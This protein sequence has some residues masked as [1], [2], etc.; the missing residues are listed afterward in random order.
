MKLMNGEEEKELFIKDL[1][2][3]IPLVMFPLVPKR[4]F[5]IQL[6]KNIFMIMLKDLDLVEDSDGEN[7]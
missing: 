4:W 5:R 6:L 3:L 7:D 2:I 1:L